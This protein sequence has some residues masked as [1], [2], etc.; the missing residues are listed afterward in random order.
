MGERVLFAG[1]A[2]GTALVLDEPVSLWGG[3]DPVTG[4]IIDRRHSQ[5]GTS[6]AGVVL[7][8]PSGRGSSGGSAGLAEA[9]RLGTGPVAIVLGEPDEILVVG[10]V[11]AEELYGV[12]VPIVVVDLEVYDAI[13]TG[14]TVT[15]R[16]DGSLWLEDG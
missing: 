15:V 13:A 4:E 9:T 7:V 2:T 10:A 8:M 12:T 16:H 3:F 14:M 5:V 6:L 11:V 1:E